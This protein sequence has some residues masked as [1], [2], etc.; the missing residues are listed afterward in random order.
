MYV[1]PPTADIVSAAAMQGH[2]PDPFD[3]CDVIICYGGAR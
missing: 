1:L 3:D 2:D